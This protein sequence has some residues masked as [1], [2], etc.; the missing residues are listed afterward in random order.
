MCLGFQLLNQKFLHRLKG[1]GIGATLVRGAGGAFVVK[2]FGQGLMFALQVLLARMMGV[3]HFGVYIYVLTWI[4]ILVLAGKLGL[5]TALLRYV[6][7]YTS[8]AAWSAAR[9][10]LKRSTQIALAASF[11]VSGLGGVIT[12]IYASWLGTELSS[13][14]LLGWLVLPV[15]SLSALRMAALRALKRVVRAELPELILRPLILAG[16]V[17]FLMYIMRQPVKGPTAMGLYLVT[18]IITFIIGSRWLYSYLPSQVKEVKPV[19]HSKEWIAVA[20]PLFLVSGMYLV[21]TQAD[22]LMLG[23]LLDTTQAGIYVTASRVATLVGFGV[24][25]VNSISAPMIASLYAQGRTKELQR[26]ITVATWG[27]TAFALPVCLSLILGGKEVLGLFGSEFSNGYP[28]LLILIIGQLVNALTGLVGSLMQMTGYQ[29]ITVQ[30]IG[31]SAVANIILNLL[32][33]PVWGM[34][35]A[36]IATA[37]TTIAWSIIL[38]YFA[39]HR[40]GISATVLRINKLD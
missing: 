11:I 9:G 7:A 16:L 3:D 27:I 24:L 31:G 13:T 30:V 23:F 34:Q 36:A 19:Y 40:L 8:Q 39:W 2:I 21:N 22:T 5:D 15:L 29:V 38:T 33:I 28:A 17:L 25:A 6:S 12:W 26:M 10:I 20:L 35:G 14:F 37:S 4:N 1:D 18:V 32:L